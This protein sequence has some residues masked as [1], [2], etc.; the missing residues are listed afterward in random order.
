MR[1]GVSLALVMMA[2]VSG[3]AMAAGPEGAWGAGPLSAGEERGELLPSG[4]ITN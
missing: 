4:A 3:E 2:L 1:V